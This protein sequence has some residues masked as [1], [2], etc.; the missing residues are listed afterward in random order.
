MLVCLFLNTLLQTQTD[1]AVISI[2]NDLSRQMSN[3]GQRHANLRRDLMMELLDGLRSHVSSWPMAL[4]HQYLGAREALENR[5]SL[6]YAI[7]GYGVDC[8]CWDLLH[9]ERG[10]ALRHRLLRADQ[11]ILVKRVMMEVEV[12][13]ADLFDQNYYWFVSMEF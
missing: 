9:A 11:P 3:I 6:L 13:C 7:Y 1:V 2:V 5:Q 8:C 10:L 12:C 4:R